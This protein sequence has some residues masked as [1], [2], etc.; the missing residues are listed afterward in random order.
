MSGNAVQP[1]ESRVRRPLTIRVYTDDEPGIS[2][3]NNS[4]PKLSASTG[5]G[6]GRANLSKR[7]RLLFD[8]DIRITEDTRFTVSIPLI[9]HPL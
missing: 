9:R 2:V 4:Q 1:N 3:S 8:R 7:Y 5:T 6:I